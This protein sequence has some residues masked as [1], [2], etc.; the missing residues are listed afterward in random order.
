ML[1][2][3]SVGDVAVMRAVERAAGE[4][5]RGLGMDAVADDEP[6]P[7]AVLREFVD[8]GRAWVVER[9][10]EVVAYLVAAVVDGCGHVEQASV[11]P[12]HAGHR[13]GAALVEHLASWS[14]ERGHPALTLTTFRDVPWNGPYYARCG[15]RTLDDDEL[16]P[17][18]RAIR[19]DEAARRLDRWPRVAMR[20]DLSPRT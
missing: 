7:V 2:E 17:G 8:D 12:D 1:R 5:F 13:Y 19:A 15:F 6:P 11:H 18:L 10:G 3:A 20:R 9:D 14:R 16:G 4:P